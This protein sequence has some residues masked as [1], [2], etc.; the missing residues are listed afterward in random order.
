ML[1]K[2]RTF[3]GKKYLLKANKAST[4][5]E[6]QAIVKKAKKQ[7]WLIRMVKVAKDKRG[8]RAY[9]TFYARKA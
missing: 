7:G 2:Y 8:N 3:N 9:Y 4:K 6:A 5:K 1:D